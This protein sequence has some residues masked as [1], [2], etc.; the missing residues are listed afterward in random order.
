MSR[1]FQ[2]R[3]ALLAA[4]R[5]GGFV[6][7]A[8][9]VVVLAF[10]LETRPADLPEVMRS[11]VLAAD[12]VAG[13]HFGLAR[14]HVWAAFLLGVAPLVVLRATRRAASK[15]TD[16]EAWLA[17][18]P[19]GNAAIALSFYVGTVAAWCLALLPF[20][21]CSELGAPKGERLVESAG[22]GEI[23]RAR[24]F[25]A[26]APLAWTVVLPEGARAEHASLEVG[27]A[28]ASG[29]TTRV[30]ARARW[31]GAEDW[32]ERTTHVT[33]RGRVEFELP[34]DSSGALELELTCAPGARAVVLS[35]HLSLWRVSAARAPVA[36]RMALR[37][38]LAGAAWCA[39]A[40]AFACFVG[41]TTAASGVLALWVAV[42]MADWPAAPR[43]WIPGAD[44]FDALEIVGLGR[45]PLALGMEVWVGT[46]VIVAAAVL[47]TTVAL[48]RWRAAR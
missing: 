30:L 14:Q 16:D 47:V 44:L 3:L 40:L 22:E 23:A 11:L 9:I 6:L 37:L 41:A 34:G 7:V 48:A 42:W 46:G 4:R 45:A 39:L 33:T 38:A 5:M 2:P 10:A 27:I 18:R 32:S 35:P 13:P 19:V 26:D 28:T 36:T 8:W 15:R 1:V 25:S 12:S 21:V 20:A 17:T 24:W 29:A 31:V 43:R